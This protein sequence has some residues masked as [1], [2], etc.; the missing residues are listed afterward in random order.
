MSTLSQIGY[1]GMRSAHIALTVTA[2]NIANVNTPGFTRLTTDLHSLAGHGLHD[3]GSG[4]QVTSIRRVVS[5]FH[6]MQLWRA[7]T[8]MNYHDTKQSY[9][10]ALEALVGSEGSS[11]S[12]GLDNFFA[13]LSE[14][15]VTPESI[16]LRQQ[17]IG[18]ANQLA[19]RFNSL[20][21]NIDAQL[22]ALHGQR[23]AT[24]GEINALAANIAEL[25]VRIVELDSTG[26]D[27]ATLRDHRDRLIK[28]LNEFLDVR[29]LELPDGSVSL[30]L[31]NGQ[32]LVARGTAG[33][34]EV[35]LLASGEQSL[36]LT[37]A[38]TKFPLDQQGLGGVLGGLYDTEYDTLR[39]TLDELH[40][41]AAALAQLVNDIHTTGYDLNGDLGEPL[42]V[43]NPASITGMLTVNDLG[44]DE[45][46]FS[47][48]AGEVGNNDKLRELLDVRYAQ[49][50]VAGNNVSLNDA[51]AG[52]LSRVASSS[53][54]NQSDLKAAT[55]VL[56]EAQAQRDRVSA[57]SLDEEAINLMT[58]TQAYQAN[59]K[60]VT[61]ANEL[62][63]SLMAM[64]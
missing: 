13:A 47:S 28:E 60:V 5:D 12:V 54:Q 57:V 33:T 20:A 46:A 29:P 39:T 59:M 24:V 19:Q 17:V 50:P 44:P 14:A 42:F 26:R 25:N 15:S 11:I 34:I 48:V 10:T 30:S 58:Y 23:T 45:L 2:Q 21:G 55:A 43:Y 35:S 41:M 37:F 36:S 38:G 3:P 9:L 1:T 18:E 8:K 52:L 31:A 63:A 27:T 32:P 16:P 22:G 6:N 40:E 56:E 51:Y 4:V 62:L 53:R 64:F 61:T 49:I 7:T